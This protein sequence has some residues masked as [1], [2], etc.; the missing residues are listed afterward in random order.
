MKLNNQTVNP[1]ENVTIQIPVANLPS[2]TEIGLYVHV[3]RSK[4]PGPTL[5]LIGGV[6]GDEINGVE[7]V[8]RAVRKKFFNKLNCGSVIAVPLLNVYGFI[9]FSRSFP[10]GKDVNRSFPGTKN[11]SL[12]SRIAYTFTSEI[13]PF[14]DFA[15]DFHTGGRSVYNYPQVRF[16][17]QNEKSAALAK[18]FG[19][20]YL[21]TSSL[22]SN[23]L[24]KTAHLKGIPSVVFEGGESLRIDEFSIDE[25]LKG[26]QRVLNHF[27]MAKFS[28]TTN[29]STSFVDKSWLRANRSGVFILEK[30]S[31]D[32]IKK[33]DVL[34]K[35]TDPYNTYQSK[36]TAKTDGFIFGHN[37]NPVVN[38]GDALFHIGFI[39][40]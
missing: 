31:G 29:Q 15:L 6:H 9:N 1:G 27:E 40:K 38:K 17:A 23:S 7:I 22:I 30:K 39:E 26:I 32:Q 5:L 35:I 13:L 28:V 36:V 33:G 37:N 12:A 11:G 24:R 3:F 20:P 34:G 4:N 19:M 8:R 16:A 2:G 18:V 25:A 14:A 10:D 21:V